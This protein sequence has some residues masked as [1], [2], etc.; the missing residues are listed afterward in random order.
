MKGK[1]QAADLRAEIARQNLPWYQLAGLVGI[2]PSPLGAMLNEK[3]PMPPEVAERILR[4]L[5][6]RHD[7][8]TAKPR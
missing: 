5:N 8:R 3:R 6:T 2:A 1:N 4:A 7:S